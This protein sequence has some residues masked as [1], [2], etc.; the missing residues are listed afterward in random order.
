M[1]GGLCKSASMII[2]FKMPAT[3][4]LTTMDIPFSSTTIRNGYKLY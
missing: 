1:I 4:K 2:L 3:S